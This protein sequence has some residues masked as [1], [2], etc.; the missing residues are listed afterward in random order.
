MRLFA[1]AT[2][3]ETLTI[4]LSLFT[5]VIFLSNAK[6]FKSLTTETLT[7]VLSLFTTVI[8]LSNAKAFKSL[9][10]VLAETLD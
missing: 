2:T 8:F 7:I 1:I 5:A 6:A 10:K 4:V 9:S 3:T